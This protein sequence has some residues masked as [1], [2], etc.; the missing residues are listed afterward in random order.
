MT[1]SILSYELLLSSIDGNLPSLCDKKGF[2]SYIQAKAV[3]LGITGFIQRTRGRDA[4]LIFE[5]SKAITDNFFDFLKVCRSQGMVEF[6]RPD[7][8]RCASETWYG[9]FTI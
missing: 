2:R 7:A 9:E 6:D 4:K 1:S 8:P 5:G 3:E